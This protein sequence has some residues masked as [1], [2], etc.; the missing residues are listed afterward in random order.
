MLPF[1]PVLLPHS[2]VHLIGVR[3]GMITVAIARMASLG[4]F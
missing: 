4:T 2:V 3:K 1:A